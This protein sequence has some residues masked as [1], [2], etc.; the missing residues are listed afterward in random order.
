MT[1]SQ[2]SNDGSTHG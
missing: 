2:N 1:Q